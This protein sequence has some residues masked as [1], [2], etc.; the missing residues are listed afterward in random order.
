MIKDKLQKIVNDSK[1]MWKTTDKK[2]NRKGTNTVKKVS[3]R[4]K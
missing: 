2:L 3:I 1:G 4:G